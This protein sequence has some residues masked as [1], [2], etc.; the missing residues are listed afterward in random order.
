MADSIQA[1]LGGL[2]KYGMYDQ[3]EQVICDL[4]QLSDTLGRFDDDIQKEQIECI[5][6]H[7]ISRVNDLEQLWQSIAG[8]IS[9][10]RGLCNDFEDNA[11]ISSDA[12]SSVSKAKPKD[13]K[14]CLDCMDLKNGTCGLPKAHVC[15]EFKPIPKTDTKYWPSA[16]Q[17]SYGSGKQTTVPTLGEVDRSRRGF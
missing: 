6:R 12:A 13:E 7:D 1:I 2:R 16:M 9:E 17:G 10:L 11:D 14:S 3:E 5:K 15:N 4:K 8:C